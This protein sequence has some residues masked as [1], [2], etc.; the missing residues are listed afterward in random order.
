MCP[1]VIANPVFPASHLRK[2]ERAIVRVRDDRQ[3]LDV[4][5]KRVC[6]MFKT[7]FGC[8]GSKVPPDQI[9]GGEQPLLRSIVINR[10]LKLFDFRAELVDLAREI[11]VRR[12]SPGVLKVIGDPARDPRL[13]GELMLF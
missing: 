6:A 10:P 13:L 1:D 4:K 7:E 5:T 2:R 11:A 8:K 9:E 3:V 12:N